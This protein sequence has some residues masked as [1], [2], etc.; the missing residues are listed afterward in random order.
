MKPAMWYISMLMICFLYIYLTAIQYIR[1]EELPVPTTA[2]QSLHGKSATPPISIPKPFSKP[3]LQFY[4]CW[5]HCSF[6]FFPYKSKCL[7][8]GWAVLLKDSS[9]DRQVKRRNNLS[10]CALTM[11]ERKITDEKTKKQGASRRGSGEGVA[12]PPETQS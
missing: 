4:S 6:R 9:S 11:P 3:L 1:G 10:E 2:R 7:K 5:W 12:S 8:Q